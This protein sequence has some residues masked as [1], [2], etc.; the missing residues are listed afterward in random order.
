MIGKA[1]LLLL[2]VVAAC[3]SQPNDI[4]ITHA[5]AFTARY[6]KSRFS[7]W[8]VR[9]TAAGHDCGVLLIRTSV[10]IDKRMVEALHYGGGPYDIHRGG[11]H[12]FYRERR[13]RGVAYQD[14][15]GAAWTYGAVTK[16]E[17]ETL[18]PCR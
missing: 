10:L 18:K 15:S 13:F 2:F 8:N 6:A 11:V 4:R 17:A 9:A 16:D 14:P 7:G 1:I 5:N 12:D 3:E